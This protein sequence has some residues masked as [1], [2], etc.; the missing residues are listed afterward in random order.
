MGH[1]LLELAEV[2]VALWWG[3]CGSGGAY[4][5]FTGVHFYRSERR[6]D[7]WGIGG[8]LR[9]GGWRLVLPE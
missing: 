7:E 1:I 5:V 4:M 9:E 8:R 2:A 3:G 6:V